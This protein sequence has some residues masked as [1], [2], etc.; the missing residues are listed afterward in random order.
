[1]AEAA[2]RRGSTRGAAAGP[3]P[4]RVAL[5]R[6]GLAA[7]EAMDHAGREVQACVRASS[8][9][10][11]GLVAQV[12]GGPAAPEPWRHY[13]D[14][15]VY[16][17]ESHAQWYFHV[18]PAGGGSEEIG[19]FHTFLRPAGMPAGCVPAPGQA[20][21][22]AGEQALCHLMAI[23]VDRVGHP[24]RLFTTNRW[25]TGETWY[26]AEATVAML[27]R[28][29]V[30]RARPS[31]TV[32]HWLSALFPLFRPQMVRLV[33]ARDEALARRRA[34]NPQE[35]ALDD[36]GLEVLSSMRISLVDQIAAV[37]RARERAAPG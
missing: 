3:A 17:P 29:R 21:A 25:V 8:R 36:R 35:E 23:A 15:D 37:A 12:T 24:V 27:D 14:D 22:G 5:G 1:M 34:A 2:R 26:P 30:E 13:P 20:A 6:L 28:F 9:R 10:P 31:W 18:H 4:A 33:R 16:D 11:G 7:I 32:N 19:H